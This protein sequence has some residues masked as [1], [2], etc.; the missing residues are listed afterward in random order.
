MFFAI[1]CK[2]TLIHLQLSM[3][4]LKNRYVNPANVLTFGN[5]LL[6][7]SAILCVTFGRIDLASVCLLSAMLCDFF[8]GMLARLLGV[9][10]ELG[11]QLDS[12]ADVVSFG[13]APGAIMFVMIVVGIDLES[14]NK[15]SVDASFCP[16]NFNEFVRVK[17]MEW[18]DA[19]FY[20]PNDANYMHQGCSI[21]LESNVYN[22]SIK[23]LPFVAG[24]IP[25]F[26]MIRLANFNTDDRQKTSF[27][28][29][30][31]PLMTFFVLFFSLYFHLEKEHWFDHASWVRSIFDCYTLAIISV[32]ISIAMILPI[33]MISLKFKVFSFRK[34][35]LRYAFL[36][37]SLISIFLFHLWSIPI[38]LL[39]YLITSIGQMV[40]F[41]DDV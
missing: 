21:H 18:S 23:Y 20:N 34:N 25:L 32:F 15:T 31:T 28:G 24:I 11:K 2:V 27:R 3:S 6:G 36:L 8:D 13:I 5:L 38:I 26:A 4:L 17:L 22:A 12:L 39:L 41:K 7:F 1:V 9:D 30:P 40:F 37:T 33:P 14:L 10:G 35:V 19:F 29:I 16:I